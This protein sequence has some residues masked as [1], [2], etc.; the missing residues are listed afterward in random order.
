MSHRFSNSKHV[1]ESIRLQAQYRAWHE[2]PIRLR[3]RILEE[4]MDIVQRQTVV[5]KCS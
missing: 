3:I 4:I 2:I 5:I 1:R